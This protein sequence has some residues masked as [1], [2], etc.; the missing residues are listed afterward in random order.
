M[1]YFSPPWKMLIPLIP[2]SEELAPMP[3][4]RRFLEKG[5]MALVLS[6]VCFVILML[7]LPENYL[8]YNILAVFAVICIGAIF[9]NSLYFKKITELARNADLFTGVEGLP[10]KIRFIGF[11]LMDIFA[12]I[13][14]VDSS[15]E[16]LS[17]ETVAVAAANKNPLYVPPFRDI[18]GLLYTTG[19]KAEE[20][21]IV[22][23]DLILFGRPATEAELESRWY[24][25]ILSMV[26]LIAFGLFM[27]CCFI[28]LVIFQPKEQSDFQFYALSGAI[29]L[30]S[31]LIILVPAL[32][33]SK[34]IQYKKLLKAR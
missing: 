13:Q 27:L 8:I 22:S 34:M 1:I 26:G 9:I 18:D 4:V 30:L 10:V 5:K 20:L 11:G 23:G 14:S 16:S 12:R 25:N 24:V 19:D 6:L 21:G 32:F 15:S 3:D 31:S 28:I 33:L 29:I 2:L 7:F 17:L